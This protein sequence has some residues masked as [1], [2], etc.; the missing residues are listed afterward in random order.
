M[1]TVESGQP[2]SFCLS[3]YRLFSGEDPFYP[4]EFWQR[5]NRCGIFITEAQQDITLN[6]VWMIM[7]AGTGFVMIIVN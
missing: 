2:L 4:F 6:S 1:D 5:S 7:M 3:K